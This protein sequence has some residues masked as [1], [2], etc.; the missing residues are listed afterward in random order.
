MT[1]GGA[2][3]RS[4]PA[5][6]P[7]SK[8]SQDRA[9]VVLPADPGVEILPAWPFPPAQPAELKQWERVWSMPQARMWQRSH[10]HAQVAQ[11]VRALVASMEPD[12]GPSMKQT[13]L[14]MESELGI[15]ITGML[16]HGWL[17]E[18]PP[19]ETSKPAARSKTTTAKRRTTS[20]TWLEGVN[21]RGGA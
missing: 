11:Y 16:K 2:R 19:E 15:S 21:V 18:T 7:R 9:W 8:R 12:A 1:S 3:P 6:D 5:P 4:G 10:L 20:G 13:V 17:H 14:R